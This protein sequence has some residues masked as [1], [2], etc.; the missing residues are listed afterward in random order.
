MRIGKKCVSYTAF[1]LKRSFEDDNAVEF[2][3]MSQICCAI[4]FAG[5][6]IYIAHA[7]VVEGGN[8]FS[9]FWKKVVYL[10]LCQVYR[11]C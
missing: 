11:N 8:F 6:V 1:S 10:L 4:D 3:I 5:V 7:S 2:F 9:D